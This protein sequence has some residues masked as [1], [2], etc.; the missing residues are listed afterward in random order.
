MTP[1]KS[2]LPPEHREILIPH[3]PTRGPFKAVRRVLI[4]SS[5]DELKQAGA[6]PRYRLLID[7]VA[8]AAITEAIG[9]GWLSA[10]LALAHYNACDALDL[11]EAVITQ[12][13]AHAGAKIQSTL[14][15]SNAKR[16]PGRSE[17][18][19]WESLGAFWRMGRRLYEGSSSQYVKLGPSELLIETIGNPLFGTRYY[20]LAHVGFLA[21]A[22]STFGVHAQAHGAYRREAGAEIAEARIAWK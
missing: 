11:D 4:H 19:P 8:F 21:A 18:S 9:P 3:D 7:D 14:L 22:F 10:E 12:L 16:E 20:Q 15:V 1:R 17:H 6:F 5:I 2:L 13:G